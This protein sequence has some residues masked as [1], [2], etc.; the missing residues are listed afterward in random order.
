MSRTSSSQTASTRQPSRLRSAIRFLLFALAGALLFGAAQAQN[1]LNAVL[2]RG[3]L[4]TQPLI[5]GDGFRPLNL[6]NQNNETTI[7]S[8]YR[9]KN[10]ASLDTF[11][12]ANEA[13]EEATE[14]DRGAQAAIEEL[15]ATAS[16]LSGVSVSKHS[17][18]TMLV[19]MDRGTYV[20]AATP[21][22]GGA[23]TYSTFEVVGGGES[24]AGP[25]VP[26]EVDFSD[27][28]FD[29]PTEVDAGVNLWK[30]SNTGTQPHVADFY[31]LLPGRTV[32]DLIAYLDG[33]G[34][35]RAP[36]DETA[37][38]AMVGAGETV[39]VPVDLKA[40]DWVALCFVPDMD[41]PE[42]T[43]VMEGMVSEFRVQ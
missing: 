7:F 39:Y 32:D 3:S 20:I 21:K 14:A 24:A 11:V 18:K 26:N 4:A 35:A 22:S 33:D 34:G 28:A 25:Q 40:G 9:L 31:R 36:Y 5:V 43:H 37:T 41:N 23:V 19:D 6:V 10:D 12:A 16:A 2:T 13:L 38:I 15:A 1:E 27:F 17:S 29:F 30:V 42:L 8:V